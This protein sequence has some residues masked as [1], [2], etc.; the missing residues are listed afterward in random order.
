MR[1]ESRFCRWHRVQ[2]F[3]TTFGYSKA[4]HI[5]T[6]FLLLIRGTSESSEVDTQ[7]VDGPLSPAALASRETLGKRS[8]VVWMSTHQC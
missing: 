5:P 8:T 7:V 1:R 2:T 4:I 6:S 3:R